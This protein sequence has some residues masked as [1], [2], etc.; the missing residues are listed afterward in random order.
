[1]PKSNCKVN[2]AH[3]KIWPGPV[4]ATYFLRCFLSGL[5]P[6]RV[7]GPGG[8]P[9]GRRRLHLQA[10]R[11]QATRVPRSVGQASAGEGGLHACMRVLP[12]Y[13][14][15][16]LSRS[17]L[18]PFFFRALCLGRPALPRAQPATRW[19]SRAIPARRFP[20][21]STSVRSRRA[22]ATTTSSAYEST[23]SRTST[24]TQTDSDAHCTTA[25]AAPSRA[26]RRA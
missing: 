23:R 7:R 26:T 17:A 15:R 5:V 24:K 25:P 9:A 10:M 18:T 13:I 20:A 19:A 16:L 8:V 2:R 22:G 12:I 4:W 14:H 21:A 1:M 11:G 6:P 3:A